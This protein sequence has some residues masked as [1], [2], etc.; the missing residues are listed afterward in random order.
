MQ[1]PADKP[2]VADPTQSLNYLLYQ[3]MRTGQDALP[4]PVEI[5][6][7]FSNCG[8]G[9][10]SAFRHSL[11]KRELLSYDIAFPPYLVVEGVNGLYWTRPPE[12]GKEGLYHFLFHLRMVMAHL[13]VNPIG[14][15]STVS[16]TE[17][18][19]M[20]TQL[21]RRAA[22]VR[23]GED[24]GVIYTDDTLSAVQGPVLAERL[25]TIQA[26]TRQKYCRPKA[27]IEGSSIPLP[28]LEPQLSSWEEVEP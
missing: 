9:F 12:G 4:I 7:G 23:S 21:P 15:K 22:F 3:V 25:E 19:H 1:T 24:I 10:Y 13:A 11:N 6:Y 17:V 5:V 14:K 18:A 20:L 27:E 28:S 2:K 8:R 26:Q 16:S